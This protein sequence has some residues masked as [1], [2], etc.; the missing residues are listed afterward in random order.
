[1]DWKSCLQGQKSDTVA[2][3]LNRVPLNVS[4][5]RQ[6]TGYNLVLWHNLVNRIVNVRLNICSTGIVDAD[7]RGDATAPPGLVPP[8]AAPEEVIVDEEPVEMVPEQEAHVAHEVIL[9]DVEPEMPQPCLYHTLMRDYEES[10]PMMMDD[11]D[12]LDDDPN[13]GCFD[14]DE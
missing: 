6:L 8:A 13:E 12:D 11:L 4:F 5:W 2:N 14:M 10:P 3:V 9:T 1:M 7:Y